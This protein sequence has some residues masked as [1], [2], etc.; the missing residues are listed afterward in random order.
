MAYALIFGILIGF[1]WLIIREIYFSIR[2]RD[3]DGVKID[4]NYF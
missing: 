1:C 2:G 3:E 4:D